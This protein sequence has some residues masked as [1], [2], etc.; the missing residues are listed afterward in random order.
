[1]KPDPD[2][3]QIHPH[4]WGESLELPWIDVG[5]ARVVARVAAGPHLHQPYGIL[6]GGA[7]CS[8]VE[9]VA[10]HGAGQAVLRAGGVGVVGVS[11]HTD[12]L[13]SHSEGT[14]DIVGEPRHAGRRQH[15]WEVRITRSDGVLVARGQVRFQ[16]LD[17]LPEERA[18][19]TIGGSR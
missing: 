2:P 3:P 19:R 18:R 15:L 11:N 7:W 9:E 14:L 12:F 17:Q 5:P 13:R 8:I 6:H 16:V 10:S 4:H 1:M